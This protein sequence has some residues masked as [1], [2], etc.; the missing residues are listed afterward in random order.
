LSI[1]Q[2]L[3][4]LKSAQFAQ[5]KMPFSASKKTVQWRATVNHQL[6]FGGIFGSSPKRIQPFILKNIFF[7]EN[8]QV[9]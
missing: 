2:F 9:T 4:T 3:N 8:K 7:L 1:I 5:G 6:Y